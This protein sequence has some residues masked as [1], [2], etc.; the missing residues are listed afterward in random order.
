MPLFESDIIKEFAVFFILIVSIVMVYPIYLFEYFFSGTGVLHYI[1]PFVEE[2]IKGLVVFYFIKK[3]NSNLKES[4]FLGAAM[5]LGYGFIENLLYAIKFIPNPYFFN[6]M[7][8][9][10]IYPLLIHINSSVVFSGM[11][12]KKFVLTG[13]VM[14]IAIHL[15]YNIAILL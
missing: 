10:F 9:R 15:I 5:G 12:Q 14:A 3:T 11:A 1:S 2:S 13:L 4:L 8:L 7:S 6:I